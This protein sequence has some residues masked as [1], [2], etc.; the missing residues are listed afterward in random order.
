LLNINVENPATGNSFGEN[1]EFRKQ[2]KL[3]K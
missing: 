2:V 1:E 3:L